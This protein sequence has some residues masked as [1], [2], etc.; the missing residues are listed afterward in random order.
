MLAAI[1][2]VLFHR[3]AMN[4][5]VGPEQPMMRGTIQ[6]PAAKQHVQVVSAVTCNVLSERV[7]S[8]EFPVM[9]SGDA[10]G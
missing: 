2:Y 6:S 4:T 10:G 3:K 1:F 9:L 8:G 5:L 7:R